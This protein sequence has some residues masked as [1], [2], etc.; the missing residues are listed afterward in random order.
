L[1][2]SLIAALPE[3]CER[4]NAEAGAV[5]RNAHPYGTGPLAGVD[6][7]LDLIP[8][9]IEGVLEGV[10]DQTLKEVLIS[11]YEGLIDGKFRNHFKVRVVRGSETFALLLEEGH[12]IH[13][14][15][16]G[17]VFRLRKLR[18][19][20][21]VFDEAAEV[22]DLFSRQVGQLAHLGVHLHAPENRFLD[23]S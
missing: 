10:A 7:H 19:Q 22:F 23:G 9:M 5:V 15:A 21:E 2:N 3:F 17:F 4:F 6:R 11:F 20:Q 12:Q 16:R 14:T 1:E 18:E 13:E 8:G